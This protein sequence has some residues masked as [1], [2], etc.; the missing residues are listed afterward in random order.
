MMVKKQI[1]EKLHFVC[2]VYFCCFFVFTDPIKLLGL[3]YI[4]SD[5]KAQN[6]INNSSSD[7]TGIILK[8]IEPKKP[9]VCDRQR[10]FKKTLPTLLLGFCF[11]FN[12]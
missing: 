8:E 11:A 9:C 5:M 2:F 4:D 10:N 1:I 3:N 6:S 7:D 12:A